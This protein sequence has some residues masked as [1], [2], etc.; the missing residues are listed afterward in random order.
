MIFDVFDKSLKLD[1][2][3]ITLCQVCSNWLLDIFV[4]IIMGEIQ[5][6]KV[7]YDIWQE[8]EKSNGHCKMDKV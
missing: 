3:C 8:K 1:S 2:Y 4:A 5:V 7:H 6:D